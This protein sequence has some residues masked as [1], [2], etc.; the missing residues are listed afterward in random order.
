MSEIMYTS[1]VEYSLIG[2]AVMFIVWRNI[3]SEQTPQ[4]QQQQYAA[5]G[6]SMG[7]SSGLM[8]KTFVF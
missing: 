4:Q 6:D 1:I 7:G 3:G 2:A 5:C 8:M